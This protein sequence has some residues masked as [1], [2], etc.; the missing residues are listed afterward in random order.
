MPST[1]NDSPIFLNMSDEDLSNQ[2]GSG[3]Y[4]V[5]SKNVLEGACLTLISHEELGL[6]LMVE[7]GFG[8]KCLFNPAAALESLC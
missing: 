4:H 3:Q 1:K 7:T 2:L 8:Q 5:L 6:V